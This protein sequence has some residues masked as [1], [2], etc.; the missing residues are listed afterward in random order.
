[1]AART[2]FA[3]GGADGLAACGGTGVGVEAVDAAGVASGV[4]L[5][6][7]GVGDGVVPPPVLASAATDGDAP[8]VAGVEVGP[9]APQPAR[10]KALAASMTR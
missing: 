3:V 2:A 4:G 1:M 5:L 7:V 9:V 6:E 10:A 8:V